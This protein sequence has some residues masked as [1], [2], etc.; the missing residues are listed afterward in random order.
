MSGIDLA[1]L[2]YKPPIDGIH[3]VPI[4]LV[5]GINIPRIVAKMIVRTG[6]VQHIIASHHRPVLIA[7]R[8]LEFAIPAWPTL[9]I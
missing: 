6:L 7:P 5:I 4:G 2:R 3:A 8:K 9:I 1:N